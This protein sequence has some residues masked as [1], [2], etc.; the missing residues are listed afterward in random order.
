MS[1]SKGLKVESSK[2][3]CRHGSDSLVPAKVSINAGV[4]RFNGSS[5]VLQGAINRLL[6]WQVG[7]ILEEP[8]LFIQYSQWLFGLMA[9]LEKPVH[10]ETCAQL[11]LL[12][13]LCARQQLESP[14]AAAISQVLAVIAGAYFRQD[15]LLILQG[16]PFLE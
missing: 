4:C 16:A 6:R 5:A 11:R 2:H 9:V 14:E 8:E 3:H 1:C 15:E 7:W 12:L 13:R 10:K